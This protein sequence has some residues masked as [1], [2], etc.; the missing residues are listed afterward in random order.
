MEAEV[1]AKGGAL[2]VDDGG[3]VVWKGKGGGGFCAITLGD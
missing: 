2:F 3:E 1:S